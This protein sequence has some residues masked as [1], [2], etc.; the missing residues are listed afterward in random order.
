MHFQEKST[1]AWFL[2][3]Q[4]KTCKQTFIKA[5]WNIICFNNTSNLSYTSINLDFR[6]FTFVDNNLH[7]WIFCSR[8]W[9]LINWFKQV[10]T[11]QWSNIC[12]LTEII[13]FIIRTLYMYSIENNLHVRVCAWNNMEWHV[14]NTFPNS[15]KSA[16]GH[17]NSVQFSE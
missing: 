14:F 2:A 13:S 8:Y 16:S 6:L 5:N 17:N 15:T 11:I 4:S 7:V 9:A 3:C 1:T 12:C 10:N